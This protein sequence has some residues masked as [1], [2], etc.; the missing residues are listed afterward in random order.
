MLIL[1][2][3]KFYFHNHN[4]ISNEN[5]YKEKLSIQS[6]KIEPKR[7]VDINI[8]LNRIKIKERNETKQKIIF[9]S[10]ISFAVILFG[11]FITL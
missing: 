4:Q 5:K 8:L 9:F 2:M 1:N 6:T 3:K 7:I 10:F 11:I